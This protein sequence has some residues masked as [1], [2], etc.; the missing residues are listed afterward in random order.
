M[1]ANNTFT[2]MS[3]QKS[4]K[5]LKLFLDQKLYRPKIVH[6]NSKMKFFFLNFFFFSKMRFKNHSVIAFNILNIAIWETCYI[7]KKKVKVNFL[8]FNKRYFFSAFFKKIKH[9]LN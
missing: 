6:F 4:Y 9:I 8:L 3:L 7:K 5:L 1:E 2:P